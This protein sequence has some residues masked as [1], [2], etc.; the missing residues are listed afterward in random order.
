[1]TGSAADA[2]DVVQET[3]ARAL[4]F[5]PRKLDRPWLQRVALNLSLDLLRRR[6]R[7]AYVGPWLPQPVDT[8][9]EP[10]AFEPE[11]GSERSTE[12]RYE[13]V[14][15]L[16]Y[17]FLLALEVLTP[18]QRAVLLLRDV[19]DYS[20][21]QTARALDTTPASVKTLHHRARRAMQ[22]YDEKRCRP[23]VEA[24]RRARGALERLVSALA[25][26]DLRQV[27][28]LLSE[29]VV[30]LSDGGKHVPAARRPVTGR[31]RVARLWTGLAARQLPSRVE[32]RILNGMPAAVLRGTNPDPIVLRVEVGGDG[33][34]R[35]I[36]S[37]LAPEKVA[38]L[39]PTR[40]RW[41]DA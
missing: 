10:P 35:E 34:V 16:S 30:S 3:F 25:R 29:D 9:D 32:I 40:K 1:M 18:K 39:A 11:A 28:A 33:K 31:E 37:I 8:S 15:S 24:R 5:R 41:W 14:E 7:R 21:E 22:G 12:G 13:L 6:K 20:V 17:A 23:T 27:E 19:F 2:D 38:T 4:T 26:R 36:H